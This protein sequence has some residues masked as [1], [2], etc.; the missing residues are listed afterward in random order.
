MKKGFTIV[1]IAIVVVVIGILAGL[2]IVGYGAWRERAAI[3]A[4]K[5]D[6]LAA[7]VV[8]KAAQDRETG[9][10]TVLPSSFSP[11]NGVTLILKPG[12]N[13]T[14]YCFEATVAEKPGVTYFLD[15]DKNTQPAEGT[16]TMP[17]SPPATPPVVAGASGGYGFAVSP[18]ADYAY[19]STAINGTSAIRR[20]SL[21]GG[22][23]EAVVPNPGVG[24]IR[25]LAFDTTGRLYAAAGDSIYRVNLD[26]LTSELVRSGFSDVVYSLYFDGSDTMYIGTRLNIHKYTVSTNTL[27]TIYSDVSSRY[28]NG[29]T[30]VGQYLYAMKTSFGMARLDLTNNQMTLT[31]TT[32]PVTSGAGNL[33]EINGI[34]YVL[35]SS[36]LYSFNVNSSEWNTTAVN[37]KESG[38][39]YPFGVAQ[40]H[41]YVFFIGRADNSQT[42]CASPAGGY[43]LQALK[44]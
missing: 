4:V 33:V 32:P 29:I 26:T 5:N 42:S 13:A 1:E 10:P 37:V 3:T 16:C 15:N 23:T 30:K 11:S 18:T 19:Y 24:T 2:T 22:T 14:F 8:M 27:A 7:D 6:L 20:V 36:T 41:G 39:T 44:P 28:F 43:A 21:A 31:Y 34:I 25:A 40:K 12:G 38:C 17:Y 9:F 35:I